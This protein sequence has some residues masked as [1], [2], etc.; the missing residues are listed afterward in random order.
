VSVILTRVGTVKDA[1][2]RPM[3]LDDV[4][5]AEELS[6]AAYTDAERFEPPNLTAASPRHTPARAGQWIART[7]HL[8]GTDPGGCWVA[9][10]SGELVGFA[11]SFRRDLLWVLASYA[12]RSGLQGQGI[13]RPLL[14]AALSYSRGCLR[15]MFASSSDPKA[16][17]VYRRAGFTLH[18]E[19]HLSGVPDRS[20]IPVVEHVREGTPGDFELMD[21]LDRQRRDA[22]HGPDHP[23][24]AGMYRL[25]V[26]DR[27]T[28]S[29]YAY[30]HESGAPQLLAAS[31][32]RTAARLLWEAIASAPA[33]APLEIA[34]VTP[35]NEWAVD[36]GLEARLS[37]STRGYLAL[38]GMRPPTPYLPHSSLL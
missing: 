13:G 6:L 25:L 33:D 15:G 24:L 23:L 36:I 35:A 28:G 7:S 30:V 21:S 32:R 34:H 5:V 8:L 18:P 3:R 26:V 9:E 22:A 31:N 19:L 16:Y 29:G 10:V 17:R 37:V 12:V 27:S 2:I 11:V 1:L 38:R 14:E 20:V 4:P